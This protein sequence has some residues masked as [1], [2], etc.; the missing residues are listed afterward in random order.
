M[1]ANRNNQRFSKISISYLDWKKNEE[2]SWD[3]WSSKIPFTFFQV[4]FKQNG[5]PIYDPSPSPCLMW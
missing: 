5:K 1:E 3:K 4:L 2:L